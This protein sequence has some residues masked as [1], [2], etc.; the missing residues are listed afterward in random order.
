MVVARYI[1]HPELHSSWT[2]LIISLENVFEVQDKTV[3]G[4]KYRKKITER[5]PPVPREAV[6]RN[7]TGYATTIHRGTP[8]AKTICGSMGWDLTTTE[9]DKFVTCKNCLLPKFQNRLRDEQSQDTYGKM[10]EKHPPKKLPVVPH[11]LN[12]SSSSSEI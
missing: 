3:S 12:S 7:A 2:D 1:Y 10:G 9:E 8:K 11:F 4:K 6:S 5:P